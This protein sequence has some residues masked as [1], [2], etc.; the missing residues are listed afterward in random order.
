MYKNILIPVV[1]ET[2]EIT[3]TAFDAAQALASKDAKLTL[4]HVIETVPIY[5]ADYIPTVSYTHL[6]LP[7]ICSV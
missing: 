7:T 4:L 1:F 5:V 2:P 3:Q 6:T